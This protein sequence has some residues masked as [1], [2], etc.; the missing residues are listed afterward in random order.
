M[1]TLPTED[2]GGKRLM[3]RRVV[4]NFEKKRVDNEGLRTRRPGKEAEERRTG[5]EGGREMKYLLL[6]SGLGERTNTANPSVLPR[7]TS[8]SGSSGCGAQQQ[9][10]QQQQQRQAASGAAANEVGWPRQL[11]TAGT[12]STA[13][14]P[15]SQRRG[16]LRPWRRRDGERAG[17]APYD[18]KAP[19]AA[20]IMLHD[21]RRQGSAI[22]QA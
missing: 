13:L 17:E 2:L 5:R 10:Q 12:C 4:V 21:A 9:Q 22:L 19:D 16:A 7:A 8:S 6:I 3:L 14:C 11:R 18:T 15:P 20:H 1:Q